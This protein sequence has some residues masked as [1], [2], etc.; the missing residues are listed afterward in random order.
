MLFLVIFFLSIAYL[1]SQA[2][3]EGI[4]KSYVRYAIVSQDF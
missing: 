3:R 4:L 1:K 2:L